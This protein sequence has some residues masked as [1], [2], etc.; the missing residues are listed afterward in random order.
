[1]IVR[2]F[3]LSVVLAA[4]VAGCGDAGFVRYSAAEAQ[5][6]MLQ[7]RLTLDECRRDLAVDRDREAELQWQAYIGD[8]ADTVA[9]AK[10]ENRTPEELKA[11][12]ASLATT[13]RTKRLALIEQNRQRT[14]TRFVRAEKH[15]NYMATI[16]AR[17][18]AQ[19]RREE[20]IQAQLAEYRQQAEQIAREKFGLPPL[21]SPASPDAPPAA[22]VLATPTSAAGPAP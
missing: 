14:D 9:K 5:V 20:S 21:A 8:Q 3:I 12:L 4:L 17:L 22:G 6:S 16:F 7:A 10:V 2:G 13:F 18:D 15:L 1:M 19:A 11:G